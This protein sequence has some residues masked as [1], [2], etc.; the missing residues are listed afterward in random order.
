[1]CS[2]HRSLIVAS[3]E[4]STRK[5][6]SGRYS[7]NTV[8]VDGIFS[9]RKWCPQ[10]VSI[11]YGPAS[12]S[13]FCYESL[14]S[15]RECNFLLK[16]DNMLTLV[17][18][19]W[20][21]DDYEGSF[22]EM[23]SHLKFFEDNDS[24]KEKMDGWT[25]DGDRVAWREHSWVSWTLFG[26][27]SCASLL[28]RRRACGSVSRLLT[29][30][31]THQRQA[32]PSL[33]TTHADAAVKDTL[34]DYD[35]R[36]FLTKSCCYALIMDRK[37]FLSF[38]HDFESV[39]EAGHGIRYGFQIIHSSRWSYCDRKSV[40]CFWT[41]VSRTRAWPSVSP[42][43]ALTRLEIGIT[44][45]KLSFLADLLA[46]AGLD[47]DS[48]AGARVVVAGSRMFLGSSYGWLL[49]VWF[50]VAAVVVT[51]R[52]AARSIFFKIY[53]AFLFILFH[54]RNLLKMGMIGKDV[55][56]QKSVLSVCREMNGNFGGINQT[57]S[58]SIIARPVDHVLPTICRRRKR[59]ERAVFLMIVVKHWIT[60]GTF[61][62]PGAPIYLCREWRRETE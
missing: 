32:S 55:T 3:P 35:H 51:T 6:C 22:S 24:F 1:M 23:V 58:G 27:K 57:H 54:T 11:L 7:T 31:W 13:S 20:R 41:T 29:D 48:A 17:L 2:I 39:W 53:W 36:V 15:A 60:S 30:G 52:A 59:A 25:T 14:L 21:S 40:P 9:T 37:A 19:C 38:N 44:T 43:H 4:L 33:K 34:P 26:R 8:T 49:Y 10:V 5:Y 18:K 62:R 45:W 16:V 28:R 47:H 61:E 50:A 12:S 56:D 46:E 42:A